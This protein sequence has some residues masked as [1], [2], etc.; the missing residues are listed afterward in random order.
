MNTK[1][2]KGMLAAVMA[3]AAVGLVG[4]LEPVP[5]LARLLTDFNYAAVTDALF[6]LLSI[7]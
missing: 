1:R 5:S 3:C 2:F 4:D 7:L 6:E